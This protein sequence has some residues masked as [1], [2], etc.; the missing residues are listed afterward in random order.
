MNKKWANIKTGRRLSLLCGLIIGSAAIAI[1]VPP[2]I[3][4][5]LKVIATAG[6][7]CIT[8]GVLKSETW[9]ERTH[10]DTYK[11]PNGHVIYADPTY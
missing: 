3:P 7:A 8:E 10:R 4:A 5:A 1:I 11:A 2:T 9:I 6:V